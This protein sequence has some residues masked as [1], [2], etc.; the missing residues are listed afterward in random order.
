MRRVDRCKLG[1][2]EDGEEGIGSGLTPEL[3]RPHAIPFAGKGKETKALQCFLSLI[4]VS[5]GQ[6]G[7]TLLY[8]IKESLKQI[9]TIE[10]IHGQD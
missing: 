7:F 6:G 10:T 2:D 1:R 4:I 3:N 8:I 5:N 9:S